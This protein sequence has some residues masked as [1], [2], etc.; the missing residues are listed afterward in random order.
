MRIKENVLKINDE[1]D[2]T[3]D[4]DGEFNTGDWFNNSKGYSLRTTP[5]KTNLI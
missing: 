2:E 3:F 1:N 4:R 5:L